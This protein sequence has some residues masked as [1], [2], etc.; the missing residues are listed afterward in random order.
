MLKR[1]T[2]VLF[3]LIFVSLPG[4]AQQLHDVDSLDKLYPNNTYEI[5]EL[6]KTNLGVQ[7][8]PNRDPSV[9]E[10]YDMVVPAFGIHHFVYKNDTFSLISFVPDQGRW[11][12]NKAFVNVFGLEYFRAFD[13][14]TVSTHW[15]DDTLKYADKYNGFEQ[16]CYNKENH[17]R[18]VTTTISKVNNQIVYNYFDSGRWK[19]TTDRNEMYEVPNTDTCEVDPPNYD[20]GIYD[21]KKNKWVVPTGMHKSI[22]ISR[23]YNTIVRTKND[24]YYQL[25]RKYR[26]KHF[27]HTS[28]D[29]QKLFYA[30][31][32]TETK[33]VTLTSGMGFKRDD[34][35]F[36]DVIVW[37][38]KKDKSYGYLMIIVPGY[39]MHNLDF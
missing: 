37:N 23:K 6:T 38:L 1:L 9:S 2:F 33:R 3:T 11:V 21:L 13:V 4:Y 22:T 19:E 28:A 14:D 12:M 36:K 25:D 27:L 29:V 24:D 8:G 10:Y 20:C 15:C 35:S 31:E 16:Y 32:W 5:P 17:E 39:D 18:V 34:Y 30:K 7:I 26:E